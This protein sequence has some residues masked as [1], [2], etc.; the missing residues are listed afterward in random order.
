MKK[1]WINTQDNHTTE[2]VAED[3]QKFIEL[4][5][6]LCVGYQ[7]EDGYI[8]F[9]SWF[10]GVKFEVSINPEN[11]DLLLTQ[12]YLYDYCKS[13]NNGTTEG[14]SERQEIDNITS[15]IYA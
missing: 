15:D 11:T 6:G 3:A 10:N 14:H 5:T 9:L 4:Q 12:K 8:T 2:N 1:H 13:W 7:E